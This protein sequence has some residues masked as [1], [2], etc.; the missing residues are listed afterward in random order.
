M[1]D[2]NVNDFVHLK[3][4]VSLSDYFEHYGK[5]VSDVPFK[6]T[7]VNTIELDLG[8]TYQIIELEYYGETIPAFSGLFL[9]TKT[10]DDEIDIGIYTN[11]DMPEGNRKNLVDSG[12]TW[13]F[14]KPENEDFKYEELEF[15]DYIKFE[16]GVNE[17]EFKRILDTCN[18]TDS[19]ECLA[20][21][22]EYACFEDI[23][24][25]RLLITELGG[26]DNQNGGLIQ[27]FRGSLID[28]SEMEVLNA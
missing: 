27:I 4:E 12:D 1:L 22:T 17:F 2:I 14:V 13:M 23:S 10:V 25:P 8:I 24:D 9:Y 19:E 16:E 7:D 11:Y 20:L 26:E 21:L 5:V 3:D 15:A 6:V 18:G 28:E